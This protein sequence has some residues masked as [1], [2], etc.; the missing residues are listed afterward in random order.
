[1]LTSIYN[2]PVAPK[3]TTNRSISSSAWHSRLAIALLLPALSVAL[4]G[5]GDGLAKVSGKVTLD[6]QPLRAEPGKLRI[7]IKFQPES[8][9]GPVAMG[10]ADE[11]GNY[12]LG[13]GSKTGI[14]PGEY[15]VT[16]SAG[17]TLTGQK[18]LGREITDSKYG[19]AKTSGLHCTVKP[20]SNKYDISVTSAPKTAKQPGA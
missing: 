4:T 11:N 15:L 1:M 18:S 3:T 9:T 5:C 10:L 6:G 13:T 17:E 7:S 19:N 20:G 2:A 16:C 14:L 8:G 12:T